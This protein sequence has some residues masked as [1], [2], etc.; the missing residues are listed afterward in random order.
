MYKLL[1]LWF[2]FML[3]IPSQAQLIDNLDYVAS[4]SEDLAAIKKGDQWA[5]ID[6]KGDIVIDYRNDLVSFVDKNDQ[7]IAPEF[8]DGRAMIKTTKDD[9]VY[10]GYIDKSGKKVIA[11]QYV[12]ATSFKDGFA[13]VMQFEKEVVGH[14]K[15]LDKDVVS[16]QVEEFIIDTDGKALTPVLNKRVFAIEQLKS[17]KLPD[18]T[19]VL[20][21]GRIVA[22]QLGEKDWEIYNF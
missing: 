18:F 19:T 1:I 20:M 10:F 15:L 13:V 22:V 4:F 9:I 5:F 17:G 12:K 14:N 6:S 8:H 16:Y 21:G 7:F 11:P 2:G 3:C